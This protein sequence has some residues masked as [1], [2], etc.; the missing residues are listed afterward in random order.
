MTDR[1]GAGATRRSASRTRFLI[2]TFFT[3]LIAGVVTF[4]VAGN[5]LIVKS[6]QP[7]AAIENSKQFYF[8]MNKDGELYFLVELFD[9]PVV[10]DLQ[11]V[12]YQWAP[13]PVSQAALPELLGFMDRNFQSR[14]IFVFSGG[15]P[16]SYLTFS[17][18]FDGVIRALAAGLLAFVVSL[19]S[20]LAR[21]VRYVLRAC[22][23][24]APEPRPARYLALVSVLLPEGEQQQWW[25]E[26]CS[27]QAESARHAHRRRSRSSGW[28]ERQKPTIG[29]PIAVQW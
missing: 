13:R 2:A 21:R 6:Y 14:K 17:Q 16:R 20:L 12:E 19:G 4:V 9:D 29:L 1:G 24:G 11:T 18:Q 7:P 15:W 22:Y 28:P 3:S 27:T 10:G 26:L 5:I 8:S 25:R 23:A